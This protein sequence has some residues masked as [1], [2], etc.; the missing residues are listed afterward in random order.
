MFGIEG[1]LASTCCWWSLDLIF[2]SR[3]CCEVG[4]ECQIHATRWE[5]RRG[6]GTD[7]EFTCDSSRWRWQWARTPAADDATDRPTDHIGVRT[8]SA[9]PSIPRGDVVPVV[10]R[11]S[12]HAGSKTAGRGAGAT[13]SSRSGNEF[14]AHAKPAVA[15]FRRHASAIERF[16]RPPATA[17]RPSLQSID[18]RRA[19]WSSSGRTADR[20]DERVQ[21]ANTNRPAFCKFRN[22]R[23][24]RP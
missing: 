12:A 21:R 18:S 3:A 11:Q 16:R 5:R 15:P 10:E 13:A 17:G 8:K 19:E 24:A 4:R 1:P 22:R 9:G 7:S 2:A 23:A 14:A 20:S 6:V